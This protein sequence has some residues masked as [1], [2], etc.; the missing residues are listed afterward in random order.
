MDKIINNLDNEL[1]I[2]YN[3]YLEKKLI[4]KIITNVLDEYKNKINNYNKII[5]E[6]NKELEYYEILYIKENIN[7]YSDNIL[8]KIKKNNDRLSSINID[9]ETYEFNININKFTKNILIKEINTLQNDIEKLNKR[10][11][12]VKRWYKIKNN[13]NKLFE[14]NLNNIIF[15]NNT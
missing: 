10:K 4:L 12:R 14:L 7:N 9:M 2:N 3:R 8:I 1:N 5:E 15:K 13:N 11:K 6:I